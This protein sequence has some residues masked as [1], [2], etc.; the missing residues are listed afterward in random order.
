MSARGLAPTIVLGL[1]IV[2]CGKSDAPREQPQ[3]TP[4]EPVAE[5]G[6]QKLAKLHMEVPQGWTS[7][8]DAASDKWLLET[9]A[10]GRTANARIERAPLAWVASPDAYLAQR[11]KYGYPGTT[12]KFEKREGVKDGF[13]MS[14]TVTAAADPDHPTRETYCVRQLGSA[15]YQAASESVPDETT[16]DQLVA[17]CKSIKLIGSR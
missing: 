6:P 11:L 7:R 15:W 1:V 5:Q 17:L 9:T 8:Y 16:R 13:A 4:P 14:V 2:A 3:A 12:A 10:D